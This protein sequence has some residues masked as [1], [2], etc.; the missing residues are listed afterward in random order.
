MSPRRPPARVAPSASAPAPEVL[1]QVRARLDAAAGDLAPWFFANMPEYYFR[2]HSREEQVRHLQ[3][4]V[5]SR[6]GD[7]PHA[8][9]L[10]SPCGTRITHIA[11]GGDMAALVAGLEQLRDE[12][13]QTARLYSSADGTLRLDTFLLGRRPMC[14]VDGPEFDRALHALADTGFDMA[15]RGEDF[16]RFLASAT[17]D[18]VEKFE[19]GRAM[20]H[21]E[22]CGCVRGTE[23]VHVR[24][25]PDRRA[26]LTRVAVAMSHP[27]ARGLLLQAVKVFARAGV[28]VRRAYGDEFTDADGETLAVLSFYVDRAAGLTARS[29][30]WRRMERQLRRIK[31]FAFHGLEPLAAERGWEIGRV[32]LMQAAC[33]FAHQFL[34]SRNP[35]AFTADRIVRTVLARPEAAEAL[36]DFFEA[37][38]APGLGRKRR[39]ARVR[40]ATARTALR[41]RAASDPVERAILACIYRFFRRVLRTNYY[42]EDRFG[43]AFRLDP[44]LLPR[45]GGE[46]PFGV[47]C[48]HGP[49]C[50]GFHVRYRDMARGGLRLVPTRTREQFELESNR[51]FGEATALARAQQLKNKDIPEG[52]AKAVLL[53]GPRAEADL[54]VRSVIDAF[55]DLLAP[56]PDGRLPKAVVDYLGREEIIYLGP[57]EHITPEHIA[58]IARR[59]RQRGY[60]WPA[61]F[62][63]SKARA[64]INHKRYGVTSEGVVVWAGEVLAALGLDPAAEPFTV[65]LTGGPAGDVAS[66]TVRIL[67]REYGE[68]ARILCLSD[69]HGCVYDPD[70]LDHGELLRLIRRGGRC[71]EF[72][73]GRLRGAG[74]F[75]LPADTPEGVRRRDD[76]HN[77][78]AA[79]LYIP[80]GGRP[81]T[82]NER[83][84]RRFLDPEG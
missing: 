21:F 35:Y 36:L 82:I 8:V 6:A 44:R 70:G 54:A 60:R 17:E 28:D 81:E 4:L 29:A 40:E 24:L 46:R 31:W 77:Q 83:N 41:L 52:G 84:W 33:G 13:I 19:P 66:N 38:L 7:E 50:F 11:P 12:H 72:R 25:E 39:A 37:R 49:D 58:W 62:M 56:G 59:A 32:Q 2:T 67:I 3:A 71:H 75:V 69:G 65:K 43:L 20:R 18:Y 64:G 23:R 57:D 30:A 55:L 53:L 42:M 26:G 80:A 76:L 10:K 27:P 9:V 45:D 1:D 51:L 16:A 48:F 74:A 73:P 5:A 68:R 15:A 78:V 63:S 79:D 61:A 14:R 22:L 34:V 47:Y